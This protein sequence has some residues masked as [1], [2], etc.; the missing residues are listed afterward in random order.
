MAQNGFQSLSLD[1]ETVKI[2]NNIGK[3]E[4]CKTVPETIRL[5]IRSWEKE[6]GPVVH[7][8]YDLFYTNSVL[9]TIGVEA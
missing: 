2:I 5:L 6:H 9:N 4:R 1:K 3:S 7:S 8:G